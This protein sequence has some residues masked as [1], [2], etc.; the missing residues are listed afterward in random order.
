MDVSRGG[1][2]IAIDCGGLGGC[3]GSLQAGLHGGMGCDGQVDGGGY[4][5]R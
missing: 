4:R 3:H 1:L 5:R 2:G